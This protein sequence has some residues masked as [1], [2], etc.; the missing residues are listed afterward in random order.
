MFFLKQCVWPCLES[1]CRVVGW[2]NGKGTELEL[3]R[4][5]LILVPSVPVPA[6]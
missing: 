2:Y 3:R 1:T 6:L 5:E 4:F